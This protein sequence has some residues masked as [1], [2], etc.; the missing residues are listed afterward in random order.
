MSV[1]KI[2]L[3]STLFFALSAIEVKSQPYNIVIKGG[4]VIDAKN[5]IDVV[6]DIAINEGKIALVAKN[7]DS[8]Q[9]SQVVNARGMLVTPGLID[10]HGHVFAGTEPDH[11]LS[12]G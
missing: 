1:K 3:F 5:N 12:N 10:I 8:S 6:T 4:R 11:Y 9:G 7:I 2:L